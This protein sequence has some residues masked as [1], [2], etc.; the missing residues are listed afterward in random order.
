MKVAVFAPDLSGGG[1]TRVY[2]IAKVL[3][4]LDLD[5]TVYGFLFGEKIY[6]VPPDNLTVNWVKGCHY[7][8]MFASI[9]QLLS[10]VDADILY[11]IKPRP[12]S[13]GMGLLKR[14][15]TRK[16]LLLD[17]DDWE[18]SWFGGENWQYRP[19]PK[20]LARDI[21]K[22]NGSLRNPENP[23]YLQWIEKLTGKA[24]LIT[25]DTRFLQQRY[26]GIYLP[27]GKDTDLFNPDLYDPET[28][29]Q[30]YN[31]SHYRVLMFPGTAR[32]HKGLED[33][34]LALDEL[35][36][37][38][39][40]LILVGGREIGD[41]Y[42]ESLLQ[43]W[44]Q[45]IIKLPAIPLDKMPEVVSAAHVVVVPQ[46]ENVTAG[47]QFPIKLTDG[48]AMAK[49]II[50]TA[51]GDIP[52]VLGDAGIIVKPDSPGEIA[53][54]IRWIFEHWEAAE[55]LGRMA[56]KHCVK[57]YSTARMATILGDAIAQFI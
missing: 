19:T 35:N 53:A 25:A 36:E 32:P 31:L 9:R 33:V 49:P 39:L 52:N 50:S 8:Q 23:L 5:V 45:W 22:P 34:L 6:P 30:Q 13:F 21:L 10:Q 7:P 44:P 42:V 47:A 41:G 2:L 57:N 51:V 1:G 29:R 46:R 18:M 12:T 17:I 27:N 56:R 14:L 3:Q 54:K 15:G 37:A 4:K 28:S 55:S 24:D 16:P 11:G 20:Q 26:G 40:R 43:R 48:M 38:D